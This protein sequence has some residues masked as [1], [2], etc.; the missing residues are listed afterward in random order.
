MLTL[1]VTDSQQMDMANDISFEGSWSVGKGKGREAGVREE[2]KATSN[3]VEIFV[4]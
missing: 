2:G 3:G 1:K 4:Q